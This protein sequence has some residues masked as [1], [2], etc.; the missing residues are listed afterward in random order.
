MKNSMRKILENGKVERMK[1]K[2]AWIRIAEAFIA[3]V[4]IFTTLLIVLSRQNASSA[5][6]DEIITLQSNI[7]Q[8]VL[9]DDVLRSQVLSGNLS[10]TYTFIGKKVPSWINYSVV[11]CSYI[12]ICSNPA[13]YIGENVYSNEIL[14]S[15]NITYLPE[16]AS[17]LKIFFWENK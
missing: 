13:G 14:I 16:N 10:G 3:I 2:K 17:R 5:R 6:S 8:S 15:S 9:R 1:S 12:D 11:N 4:L 7:L